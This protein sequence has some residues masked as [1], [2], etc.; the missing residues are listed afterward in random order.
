MQRGAEHEDRGNG[1]RGL[2]AEPG[3]GIFGGE[4][5]RGGERDDDQDGDDV[6]AQAL[7]DKQRERDDQD[8]KE[9]PLLRRQAFGHVARELGARGMPE[10]ATHV[11]VALVVGVEVAVLLGLLVFAAT[12]A[13]PIAAPP[14]NRPTP[15][16]PEGALRDCPIAVR[17]CG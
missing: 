7:G 16:V 8:D 17:G 6:V 13:I 5:A 10:W 1:D 4:Q 2:A 9:Q 3:Q 12:I 15:T 11:R 14:P